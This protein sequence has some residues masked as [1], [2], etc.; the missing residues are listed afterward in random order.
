MAT[1][2]SQGQS[3]PFT[4]EQI[5]F[6][7]RTPLRLKAD[8]SNLYPVGEPRS[9]AASNL[10]FLISVKSALSLFLA[11]LSI[12][13]EVLVDLFST[14]NYW[15]YCCSGRVLPSLGCGGEPRWHTPKRGWS[16]VL[17]P[18]GALRIRLLTTVPRRPK[19][20]QNREGPLCPS[21]CQLKAPPSRATLSNFICFPPFSGSLHSPPLTWTWT[22]YY[23]SRTTWGFLSLVSREQ[24]PQDCKELLLNSTSRC[25]GRMQT[26]VW[27]W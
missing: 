13:T 6:P 8:R 24:V 26:I 16:V 20:P 15:A 21:D 23:P 5:P 27:A 4:R 25:S 14:D 18:E 2:L 10:H 12:I 11:P 22:K 3:V 17:S 19:V 1:R 9:D 7:R